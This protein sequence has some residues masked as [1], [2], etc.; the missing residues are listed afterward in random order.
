MHSNNN[1]RSNSTISVETAKLAAT[2][3]AE[4]TTTAN[5]QDEKRYRS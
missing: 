1:K 3:A 2:T 5:K 4:A